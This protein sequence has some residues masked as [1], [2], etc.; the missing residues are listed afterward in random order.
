MHMKTL[1]SGLAGVIVLAASGQRSL[2]QLPPGVQALTTRFNVNQD[3]KTVPLKKALADLSVQT[4]VPLTLDRDSLR[5]GQKLEDIENTPVR[6]PKLNAVLMA[7]LLKHLTKQ[8]GGSY[9]VRGAGIVI[10]MNNP[11]A[12]AA[13]AANTPQ[14]LQIE[15]AVKNQLAAKVSVKKTDG[16]TFDEALY[17]LAYGNKLNILVDLDGFARAGKKDVLVTPVSVAAVRNQP[18]SSVLQ[19]LVAQVG[20]SHRVADNVIWIEA[21][22]SK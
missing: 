9:L 3:M 21:G 16:R 5:P 4:G 15:A 10:V 6:L 22:K 14:Q 2:A 8:V 11:D 17:S 12:N 1:L 18:L 7:T 13:T 19:A 20:G